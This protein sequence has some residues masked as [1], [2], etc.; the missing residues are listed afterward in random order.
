MQVK[1][2]I[3]LTDDTSEEELVARGMTSAQLRDIYTEVFWNM[4]QRFGHKAV[5]ADLHVVVTD[6]TKEAPPE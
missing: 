6:N 2:N 1:V 3:T 5:K 4:F